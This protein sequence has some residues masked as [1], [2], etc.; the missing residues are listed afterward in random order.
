M[1]SVSDK[2][3]RENRIHT[4]YDQF[5]SENCAVCETV[6]AKTARPEKPQMTIQYGTENMRF[7]FRASKA[8]IQTHT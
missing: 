1:R 5:F 3:C 2:M 7:A 4:F 6:W 8:R